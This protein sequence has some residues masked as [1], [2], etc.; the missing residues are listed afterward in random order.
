MIGKGDG[1]EDWTFYNCVISNKNMPCAS[2]IPLH[3]DL[4]D[5]VS[6]LL[7]RLHISPLDSASVIGSSLLIH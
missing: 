4:F 3:T 2:E 7:W 6:E 5:F 1:S